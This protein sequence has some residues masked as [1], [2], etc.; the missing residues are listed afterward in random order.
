MSIPPAKYPRHSTIN[1]MLRSTMCTNLLLRRRITKYNHTPAT[2]NTNR[3]TRTP[4]QRMPTLRPTANHD[5]IHRLLRQ[6]CTIHLPNAMRNNIINTTTTRLTR[7]PIKLQPLY[8]NLSTNQQ[9]DNHP[10]NARHLYSKARLH[11]QE[12]LPH[13]YRRF[14][15]IQ[16][17]Q[18][19]VL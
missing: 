9:S 19:L 3:K 12:C 8:N 14:F 15:S 16:L 13:L 5:T 10:T 17:N 2:N 1:S 7:R 6:L 11:H 4:R 18:S